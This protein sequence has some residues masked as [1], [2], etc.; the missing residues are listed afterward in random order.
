MHSGSSLTPENPA[1]SI[2]TG[3]A[4]LIIEGRPLYDEEYAIHSS[5]VGIQRRPIEHNFPSSALKYYRSQPQ[6][7]PQN[8]LGMFYSIDIHNVNKI[9][10]QRRTIFTSKSIWIF[11]CRCWCVEVVEC[12]HLLLQRTEYSRR[13]IQL[14]KL[15]C[16]YIMWCVNQVYTWER[17]QEMF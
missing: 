15:I 14:K 9:I 2:S 13:F 11:N 12:L 10:Q 4:A 5:T 3:I 16:M 17:A 1:F 7:P 8:L 6:S